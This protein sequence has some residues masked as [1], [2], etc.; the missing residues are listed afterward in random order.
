MRTTGEAISEPP[1]N[2]P[3]VSAF[4]PTAPPV[5]IRFE[6]VAA[7]P[8]E[9]ASVATM[10]MP[11]PE[12]GVDEPGDSCGVCPAGVPLQGERDELRWLDRPDYGHGVGH[13]QPLGGPAENEAR[14]L[15]RRTL[16]AAAIPTLTVPTQSGIPP[17]RRPGRPIV[18]P[19]R[20]I[21]A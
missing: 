17:D 2:V 3:P 20:T 13:V 14:W 4:A 9:L 6:V 15:P 19:G 21:T 10:P 16:L 1:S 8:A 18:R 11:V 7:L 12:D 5:A